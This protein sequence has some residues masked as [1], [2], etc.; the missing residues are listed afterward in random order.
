MSNGPRR[1]PVGKPGH[2]KKLPNGTVVSVTPRIATAIRYMVHG[3]DDGLPV[4]RAAAAKAAGISDEHLRKAFRNPAVVKAYNDELDVLRT[5][6][7]ARNLHAAIGIRDDAAMAKSAAGNGVRLHA[8]RFIE[9]R[10][11]PANI[12]VNVG[13]QNLVPGYAITM[14]QDYAD[15]A[16]QM[17]KLAGSH[18]N[19][20]DMSQDVPAD[21]TGTR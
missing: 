1:A 4:N 10:D 11:G 9:G 15:G 5:S 2:P 21:T 6:E 3:T 19:V 18:A 14:P 7:R 17:L 13:V 8:A 20:L 12:N 16:R